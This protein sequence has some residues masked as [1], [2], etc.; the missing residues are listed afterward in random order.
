MASSTY[1]RIKAN[2]QS[3]LRIKNR[4][5]KVDEATCPVCNERVQGSVE[6]LNCHVEMCLRKHGGA[7]EEDENVDV[8][9]D[10]EMYEDFEWAG[11]RRIRATSLLMG[12]FMDL[13]ELSFSNKT[14]LPTLG[15]S[16]LESLSPIISV[17][18]RST[19]GGFLLTLY[20]QWLRPILDYACTTWI[21]L[22]DTCL[23][24]TQTFQNRCLRLIVDAPYYVRNVTLH[25]N[26]GPLF[27]AT[28]SFYN[29][30][31]GPTIHPAQGLV[32]YIIDPGGCH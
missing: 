1:Q 32:K 23:R 30:F 28:Q 2:R 22:A 17:P 13:S 5:R 12:G 27:K 29:R 6:D 9:G 4:K 20:K 3:R 14:G 21:H 11:Q 15:N 31:P 8:E 18:V 16:A 10:V 19:E 26:Q 24:R 7:P 25:R